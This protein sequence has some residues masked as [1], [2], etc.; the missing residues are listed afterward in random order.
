MARVDKEFRNPFI[1]VVEEQKAA[2]GLTIA[3]R[4][5]DFL[6]IGFHR[7]GN[8]GMNDEPHLTTVNPHTERVGGNNDALRCIHESLLHGLAIGGQKTRMV[9][10][11]LHTC[12]TKAA[13][14]FVH[15]LAG[16]GIDDS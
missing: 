8:I 13:V 14:N 6:V 15:I 2:G 4:A 5:A 3:A 11:A 7:V 9:C 1:S 16:P 10:R 12:A